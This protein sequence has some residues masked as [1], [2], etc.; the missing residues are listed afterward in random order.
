MYVYSLQDQVMNKTKHLQPPPR[1][2]KGDVIPVTDRQET[3]FD[4]MMGMSDRII[5]N[6]DKHMKE[7]SEKVALEAANADSPVSVVTTTNDS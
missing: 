1:D 5:A 6:M 3:L 4:R 2:D 7:V